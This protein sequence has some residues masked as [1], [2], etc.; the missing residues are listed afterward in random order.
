MKSM[1][2]RVVCVVVILTTTVCLT[3]CTRAGKGGGPGKSGS[4]SGT[5]TSSSIGGSASTAPTEPSATQ[6][7]KQE[8]TQAPT[9][10]NIKTGKVDYSVTDA[11]NE[12]YVYDDNLNNHYDIT[13]RYPLIGIDSGDAR[14][15]NRSIDENYS[16]YCD[17]VEENIRKGTSAITTGVNY[18]YWA[19]DDALSVL[20]TLQN[21]W[22]QVAYDVYNFDLHDGS[23]VDTMDSMTQLLGLDKKTVWDELKTAVSD[24]FDEKYINP[25]ASAQS[26]IKEQLNTAKENTLSDDNLSKSEY[27]YKDNSLYAKVHLYTIAGSDGGAWATVM[28]TRL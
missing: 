6:P 8:S 7:S 13:I 24:Y 25:N 16:K 5:G 20:I 21:D 9:V 23:S 19:C 27:F 18:E 3:A 2:I 4:G 12:H 26:T 22:G 11:V 1:I 28:V 15:V 10:I 14:S 17:E